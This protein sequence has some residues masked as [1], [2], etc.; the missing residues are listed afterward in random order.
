MV[1]YEGFTESSRMW[2]CSW[3]GTRTSP[4]EWGEGFYELTFGFKTT[5]I[6]GY[7]R[8]SCYVCGQVGIIMDST[9]PDSAHPRDMNPEPNI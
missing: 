7:S 8:F 9:C 5:V 4:G 2:W 6:A 3:G 1:R